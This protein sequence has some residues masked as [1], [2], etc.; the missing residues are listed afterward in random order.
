M[1]VQIDMT[2]YVY[3][4]FEG[5]PNREEVLEVVRRVRTAIEL[6]TVLETRVEYEGVEE[7]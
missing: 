2:V 5:F 4:D 6:G 7:Q 1:K 3:K